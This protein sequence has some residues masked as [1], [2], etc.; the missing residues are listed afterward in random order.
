MSVALAS[1]VI[2]DQRAGCEW[3]SFLHAETYPQM[4]CSRFMLSILQFFMVQ[5]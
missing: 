3:H 1:D 4:F 5:R 2:D